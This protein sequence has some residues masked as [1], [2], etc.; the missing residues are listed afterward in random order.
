[1][2]S[3]VLREK[4]YLFLENFEIQLQKIMHLDSK[5]EFCIATANTLSGE[6]IT[7][8]GSLGAPAVNTRYKIWAEQCDHPKYGPQFNISRFVIPDPTGEDIKVFLANYVTGIG[9]A[10]V[11]KVFETFGDAIVDIFETNPDKLLKVP[12]IGPAKLNQI[13]TSWKEQRKCRFIV[14]SLLGWGINPSI[15]QKILSTWPDPLNIIK[16]N[17]YILI[18]DIHGVGFKTADSIA[19]KI[20]YTKDSPHR[21][22]AALFTTIDQALSMNGHCYLS[23]KALIHG[24]MAQ[25][26]DS[27][28]KFAN[29]LLQNTAQMVNSGSI[30]K[31][32]DRY[33][34]PPIYRMEIGLATRIKLLMGVIRDLP[35]DVMAMLQIYEEETGITLHPVQKNAVCIAMQSKVSI[36]TEGPGTGKT[37][38]MKAIIALAE[39]AGIRQI[40]LVAPTGRAAKRIQ[41]ATELSSPCTI[42]RYLRYNPQE[43]FPDITQEDD[44]VICDESSMIDLA[45]AYQLVK[46]LKPSARVIFIGDIDQLPSIGAGQFLGDLINSRVVP[47]ARLT[48]IFRQSD[49]SSISL[50]AAAINRGAYGEIDLSNTSKDFFWIETNQMS[51]EIQGKAITELICQTIQA[52]ILKNYKSDH[53]QVL[54]PMYRG[55]AGV[56]E[57]NERLRN[58]L[59]PAGR[60]YIIRGKTYRIGDRVIQLRNDYSRGVFNGDQGHIEEINDHDQVLWVKFPDAGVID[61]GFGDIASNLLPAYACTVHRAQGSEFPVVVI[62][63]TTGHYSML[64]RQL[65]YTAC[66]RAKRLCIMVGEKKALEIA[67]RNNRIAER[68]TALQTRLIEN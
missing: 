14:T 19:S 67:I 24:A 22:Q 65:F 33:F 60:Q 40:S 44:M 31:D 54:A 11:E 63:V 7:V 64:Q 48:H 46:S 21:L 55:D 56:D 12:G 1:M 62:P 4:C 5:S 38:I 57:L 66:T 3:K 58:V 53:I 23:E 28:Y 25:I 37:T 50:A 18:T 30:I 61:Y 29:L 36:I 10:L 42:H 34:S 20:G 51:P 27:S 32:N 9:P 2:L 15:I 41:E 45:L 59:N 49:G 8:K 6:C 43:G 47:T 16:K 39:K 35:F 17:P 26:A 68:N 13:I 52:L